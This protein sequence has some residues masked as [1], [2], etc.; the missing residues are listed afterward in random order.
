MSISNLYFTDK[1]YENFIF[2]TEIISAVHALHRNNMST[3]CSQTS[4]IRY[5]KSQ[6][7]NVSGLVLQLVVFAQSIEARCKVENEDVVDDAPTTCE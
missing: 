6:N 4:N 2:S 3:S 7:L 1:Q 5:T